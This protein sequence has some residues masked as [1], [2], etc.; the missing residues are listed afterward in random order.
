MA[1]CPA[2]HSSLRASPP[3]PRGAEHT[4]TLN[5]LAYYPRKQRY[6]SCLPDDLLLHSSSSSFQ[7]LLPPP[8][9]LR[10]LLL[11]LPVGGPR[12]P[13]QPIIVT[14]S[15]PYGRITKP[16]LPAGPYYLLLNCWL[17]APASA[18]RPARVVF[19]CSG[20]FL[21]RSPATHLHPSTST[22]FPIAS[23]SHANAPFAWPHPRTHSSAI[24]PARSHLSHPG[25]NSGPPTLG[26]P[27]LSF[28]CATTFR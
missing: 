19:T 21:L 3:R 9:N 26:T 1:C 28:M 11:L 2:N 17:L 7:L 15:I 22:T 13:V 24:R 5:L 14:C 4:H 16:R 6:L 12:S 10:R 20:G 18:T 23:A 25:S 8:A 27:S